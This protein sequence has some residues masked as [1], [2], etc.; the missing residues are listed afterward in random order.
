MKIILLSKCPLDIEQYVEFKMSVL[1]S[2]LK[3]LIS[4]HWV[5]Y[6]ALIHACVYTLQMKL[7]DCLMKKENIYLTFGSKNYKY[8]QRNLFHEC[9]K[10]ILT[11]Y[12]SKHIMFCPNLDEKM[13]Q[14]GLTL[15][16]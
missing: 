10:Y 4:S 5:T 2:P 3:S 15:L 6:V 14:K 11:M 7:F 16:V 13:E 8:A 1:I 12:I 9:N